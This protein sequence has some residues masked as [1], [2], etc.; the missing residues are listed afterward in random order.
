MRLTNILINNTI[1]KFLNKNK[2]C[3]TYTI[4]MQ[5]YINM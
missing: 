1:L 4:L 2:N 3:N 5:A